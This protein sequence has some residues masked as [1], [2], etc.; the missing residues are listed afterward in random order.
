MPDKT[1]R[2]KSTLRYCL[3]KSPYYREYLDAELVSRFERGEVPFS[4]IPFTTK[5]DL[6][7][8]NEDFC[9]V[10][11][12]AIREY[13]ATSGTTGNPVTVYLSESDLERLAQNEADSFSTA[14]CTSNDVFQLLTT[15]DKQF[16]AGLAYAMGV[17]RL[18]AGMI[19]IGPGV[20]Q[21]QW[22]SVHQ[23][24]P[25]VL[26]AVPSFILRL[27]EYAQAHGIDPK[28]SAVER[29]VCIGEPIRNTDFSLNALGK[30]ITDQWPVKLF[31]TY[32]ST[33]MA[34]AFTEC[35]AGMG[36]H[37]NESLIF[38]EVLDDE[39][40]HVQNGEA[41]EIVI[42]TLGVE[43]MPLVRFRTGDIAQYYNEKCACGRTS[44]R[45]GPITGRKNQMIKLKGT[46]IFPKAI[47][48]ILDGFEHIGNYQVQ[49]RKNQYMGDEVQIVLESG[50]EKHYSAE[51]LMQAFR[52][53]IRVV[54]TIAFMDSESLKKLVFREEKRK[55]DKV[56]F[57]G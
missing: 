17:R 29:I 2:L 24:N 25:T 32:A 47:T 31:S 5:E 16:M 55:P 4:A 34:T 11:R 18:E 50:T 33:E 40:N 10:S 36:C 46:T 53:S 19:R 37:E 48:D 43:G 15:V 13:V 7:A 12:S 26:I 41:G 49:V 27:L 42:T 44:L 52:S 14:G 21:L 6:S 8:R 30:R 39:G 38:T 22:R 1:K 45:L 54:P 51:D 28:K 9:C 20:P 57:L 35:E 56:V 3:E 23:Y